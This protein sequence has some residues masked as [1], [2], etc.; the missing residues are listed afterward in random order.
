MLFGL[1]VA[2]CLDGWMGGDHPVF[3]VPWQQHWSAERIAECLRPWREQRAVPALIVTHAPIYPPG[4]EPRYEGAEL[5][6]A[7]WWVNA[8]VGGERRS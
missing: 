3:G 1:G 5:T 7:D 8:V 2:H 4:S 6:P